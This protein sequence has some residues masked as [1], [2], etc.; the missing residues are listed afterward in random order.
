MVRLSGCGSACMLPRPWYGL[1]PLSVATI[2]GNASTKPTSTS[3]A[4][5]VQRTKSRS[6]RALRKPIPIPRKLAKASL[7]GLAGLAG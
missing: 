5:G 4:S 3:S 2:T 7:T 6:D 1:G